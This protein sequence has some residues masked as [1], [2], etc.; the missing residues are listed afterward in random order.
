MNTAIYAGEMKF[1]PPPHTLACFHDQHLKIGTLGWVK[2]DK[3]SQSSIEK[4][5]R[6]LIMTNVHHHW[7]NHDHHHQLSFTETAIIYAAIIYI[8]AQ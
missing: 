3:S 4:T 1:P 8:S 2:M 5:T 7:H 6:L